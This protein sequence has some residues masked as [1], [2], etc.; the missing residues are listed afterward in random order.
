MVLYRKPKITDG[1]VYALLVCLLL[2]FLF[3]LSTFFLKQSNAL[4]QSQ[5]NSFFFRH[6]GYLQG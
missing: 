2:E 1:F 3:E 6:T 5:L 4:F